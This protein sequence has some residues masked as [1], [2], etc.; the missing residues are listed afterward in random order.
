LIS[1]SACAAQSPDEPQTVSEGISVCSTPATVAGIDISD[2]QGQIDWAAVLSAGVRFVFMKATQGTYN[3]Q[4][5][6]SA[7]WSGA[8]AAGVLRGAYHF[9]DP[10]EDGVAQARH[11]LSITGTLQS[12]DLPPV[13]DIECPNSDSACLGW[14]GGSGA[15]PASAIRTRLMDFLNTVQQATGRVPVIYTSAGYFAGNGIVTTDLASYPLW[16]AYPT[17][18]GCYRVPSPWTRAAVWQHSWTGHVAGIAGA[19]DLNSFVGTMDDLH[20]FASPPVSAMSPTPAPSPAPAADPCSANTDCATCTAQT[21][22][23]WCNGQ[24]ISGTVSGP[25][26]VTC[27]TDTWRWTQQDCGNP[28]SP[29]MTSTDPCGSATDCAT[30]TALSAC[31]WCD[32][33]CRSGS[34]NGPTAGMCSATAWAWVASQCN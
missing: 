6:F 12:D 23:G 14:A 18:S 9:F 24:C 2:A 19:V 7:N 34:V 5:H 11:F 1:L 15:A 33:A 17:T 22:C 10:T 8:R 29:P 32:G 30:C 28:T 16:I 25:S 4:H 3:A 26:G 21:A 27:G 20:A 31:G 13:V